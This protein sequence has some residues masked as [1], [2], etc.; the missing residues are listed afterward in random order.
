MIY[1][2]YN[3][4]LTK[5][6][7]DEADARQLATLLGFWG[8]PLVLDHRGTL[9]D[10]HPTIY[11]EKENLLLYEPIPRYHY[12]WFPNGG[13]F[14][15]FNRRSDSPYLINDEEVSVGHVPLH[16]PPVEKHLPSPMIFRSVA[17]TVEFITKENLGIVPFY[18]GQQHLTTRPLEHHRNENTTIVNICQDSFPWNGPEDYHFRIVEDGIILD[19]LTIDGRSFNKRKICYSDEEVIDTLRSYRQAYISKG[20]G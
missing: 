19:L 5:L 15:R 3:E 14:V 2:F 1:Y 11:A 9:R 10:G 17:T 7:G 12:V 13:E 4:N 8:A 18:H 16:Y 20:S 6:A